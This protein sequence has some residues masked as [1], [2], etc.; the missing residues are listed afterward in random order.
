MCDYYPDAAKVV[1]FIL[2]CYGGGRV[3]FCSECFAG[4]Y[5]YGTKLVLY[6]GMDIKYM[7]LLRLFCF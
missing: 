6:L 7:N 1:L 4:L 2:L 3:Y 5:R